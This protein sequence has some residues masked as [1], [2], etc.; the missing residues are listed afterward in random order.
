M[1]NCPVHDRTPS[2]FERNSPALLTAIAAGGIVGLAALLRFWQLGIRTFT[3][4]E[5][6]YALLSRNLARGG[7]FEHVPELHGPLPIAAT[8]AIFRVFGDSDVTA[9]LAPALAGVV[10]AALPFLF[11]RFIGRVGAIAASLLLAVSPSL[12][13]YSRYDGPDVYLA[14]S[15]LATAMVLWR[16]LAA[17][18]RG[19]L[20]LLALTLAAMVTTSEIALLIAPIFALYLCARVAGDLLEQAGE[21]PAPSPA[22]RTHYDALGVAPE[23]TV[24]EIRL[25]YKHLIDRTDDRA[26]REALATSYHLLTNESRRAAYDRKLARKA[27]DRTETASPAPG[28][29]ARLLIAAGAPLIALTWP[30]AGFARRRLNLKTL[31]APADALI[32]LTLLLAP[33]Y[34]PLVEKLSFIGDRGFDGQRRIV[35]LG[36]TNVNPGGELP[37]MFTTLGIIFAVALVLGLAWKWHAFVIAWAAFYGTCI[38][39]FTG[40]FSDRGGVWS[41]IWGTLDYTWRPETRHADGPTFYYGMMLPLYEFLPLAACALGLAALVVAGGMRN[42]IIVATAAL[43]LAVIFAVRGAPVAGG[44]AVPAAA[45]VC[46]AAVVALRL[47]SLTKF[48]AFWAV[49]A[50]CAFS[51]LGR[52]D[53]WLTVHVAL[54]AIM[55]AGKLVNDAI[56]AFELPAITMPAVAVPSFR[57]YAPRRLAQGAVAAAFAMLAV[58]TLRT[59]VLA[60]W[61]HGDVPQLAHSLAPRDHG[62]TPIELLAASQNASE[63]A[64]DV[65]EMSTAIAQAAAASP[66]GDGVTIV[67]DSS[68]GFAAAWGWYLRDYKNLTVADMSK[69]YDAP[70]G[71]IVLADIRNRVNV[72]AGAGALALTFTRAWSLPL[73]VD[74]LTTSDVTSRVASGDGWSSW[75]AYAR[76]RTEIGAPRYSEGVAYFPGFLTASVSLPRQS[77]VLAASVGP[78]Q[79]H[80]AG[81][82]ASATAPAAL[83][84]QFAAAKRVVESL[85]R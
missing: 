78:A 36:G 5:S 37:V 59:G 3:E 58:F 12:L 45:V 84:A 48:L 20:Y 72:H 80:P 9:R 74:A 50:F 34:G 26:A 53:P 73:R 81:A 69:P 16:Y 4:D 14:L 64:P 62:D 17:P 44:Y 39:L 28:I 7:G 2:W 31:P 35:V 33:F 27:A 32:V 46:C 66:Q 77:D 38:T 25:A 52:K 76:D 54:P 21:A 68:R 65:R 60:G 61:G 55:L 51:M 47:P 10:L 15:T 6:L 8:A 1:A 22:D 42:R 67:L 57:A 83:E 82:P 40:F 11:L 56:A 70:D 43:L 41:G 24:R 85:L 23:A 19:W 18:S 29:G 30:F 79:L 49:G 71:A 13:Y 63:P 75:L